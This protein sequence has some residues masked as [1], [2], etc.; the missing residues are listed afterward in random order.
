MTVEA[1]NAPFRPTERRIADQ[2]SGRLAPV[3]VAAAP[4]A[5]LGA[6]QGGYFPTTWGWVT[7]P[8]LWCIGIVLVVRPGIRLSRS[9]LVFVAALVAVTGWVA[10]STAWSVAPAQTVLE[11]ER[12]ILYLAAITAL[13]LIARSSSVP[14]LLG[15]LLFAVTCVS[16]FSLA[17]RLI[18]DRVGVF[19]PNVIYR[20]AQPIGY[21]NGLALFVAMGALLALGFAARGQRIAT[22]AASAG[23]LVLLM[24]T[25]YFT[26]GRAG[27]IALGLG[28]AVAVLVDQRR[29]QLMATLLVVAPPAAVAIWLA[30]RQPGLTRSG[31]RLSQ[32]AHDGHRLALVLLALAFASAIATAIFAASERRVTVPQSVSVAFGAGVIVALVLAC[33]V[34]FVRYGGPTTL[35]R[36]AYDAFQTPLPHTTNLNQRFLSFSGNHRAELW[37]LAWDDARSHPWLGSGPGT[38]ERYY[39]A[40]QPSGI[41]RVRDAHSLYLETLAELGPIGLGLLVLALATPFAALSVARRHPLVPAAAGAYVAYLVHAGVDWDWEL[42][43]IT[44]MGLFCGAIILVAGR[45]RRCPRQ[46]SPSV[47][48]GAVAVAVALAA[49]AGIG[50]IGNS[51]LGASNSARSSG[52]WSRAAADA[53][54]AQ[55]WMPWSPSP[56]S[57]L[58]LAQL[59][60]GFVPEARASFEKA[61]SIDSGDWK[62]WYDLARASSGQARRRALRN[63]I[64]LF[65]QSGLK[66]APAAK[67]GKPG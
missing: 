55:Q 53:R 49:F 34:V 14:Q 47:R 39:L 32:A 24:P 15:G 2:F 28:L 62:L 50:Q 54:K 3:L 64:A 12:M 58:G 26:F 46:I 36:K 21:W 6:V 25:F 4:V 67:K 63:A 61:L 40:H 5:A 9:E 51:A 31:P 66:V 42:P 29:L 23:S 18:P 33:A 11:L 45:E 19:D 57:A 41:G 60:A 43:A 22:R 13:L 27:W 30:S 56:W 59:E 7:L 16:A 35:S 65:R 8:L 38:Y 37:R 10:V 20:L 1:A 52:N 17:T 48:W 44:L